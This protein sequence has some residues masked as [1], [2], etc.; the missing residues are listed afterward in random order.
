MQLHSYIHA[1]CSE[2]F[3]LMTQSHYRGK[4]PA[5]HIGQ[6]TAGLMVGHNASENI[7]TRFY[8]GNRKLIPPSFSLQCGHYS[9]LAFFSVKQQR[10]S[11]LGRL[12]VEVS[13]SHTIRH[14]HTYGKTTLKNIQLGPEA[15][16]Y[17]TYN[18]HKRRIFM[19]LTGFEPSIPAIK[20]LQPYA[21]TA[22]PPRSVSS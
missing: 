13:R 14:P 7:K 22:R 9:N 2:V 21:L 15:A 5:V 10:N 17:A 1:S 20:S 12:T 11:S 18:K 8:S 4:Q 19:P 16:F 6:K 3:I